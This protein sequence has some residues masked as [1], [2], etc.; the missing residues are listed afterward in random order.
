[1]E[2]KAVILDAIPAKKAE[3]GVTAYSDLA[4]QGHWQIVASDSHLL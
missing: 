1:M 3:V 4:G 2:C